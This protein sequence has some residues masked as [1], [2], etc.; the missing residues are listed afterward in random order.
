MQMVK[1]SVGLK[2]IDQKSYG[3]HRTVTEIF[4]EDFKCM[5][6]KLKQ[7]APIV[8]F[9]YDRRKELEGMIKTLSLNKYAQDS[10]LFV[11]CDGP[12]NDM[13]A[14]KTKEV[15]D[16]V[17]TIS[18]FRTVNVSESNVNKGLAPSIISGVTKILEKY[19]SVIVVEDDLILSTNFLAWMNEALWQYKD[20]KDVFSVSG[21]CPS[22]LKEDQ[23]YQYDAFFTRKAHSWGWATWKDRWQQVDWD[24]LDWETFSQSKKLQRAFNSIGSEMSGLLFAQMNGVKSSWWVR[25]CYSQFK[26]GKETVYPVR[27]KVINDGFTEEA[28]H[29]N[30]Y[31]RYRVDFDTSNQYVFEFPKLIKHDITLEKRF[32]YYYSIRA[33]IIGKIKTQL[34]KMGLIK[35][36][37]ISYAME[38]SK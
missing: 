7:F 12:K 29:C 8:I 5:E 36:Y 10:D 31:N 14:V 38:D 21:F 30:V 19:D 4:I 24:I 34:M 9:C 28:T 20:N 25:F 18:G 11:F 1:P 26:L 35:Q 2:V 22:V 37:T 27:S 15:R 6:N 17:K 23:I 33:R 32:F 16:Y 3:L 13:A